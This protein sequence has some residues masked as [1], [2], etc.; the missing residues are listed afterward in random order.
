MKTLTLLVSICFDDDCLPEVRL[1]RVKWPDRPEYGRDSA[2][3]NFDDGGSSIVPR[4]P[5]VRALIPARRTR[6]GDEDR[7]ALP[8]ASFRMHVVPRS[9]IKIR[10]QLGRVGSSDP[11]PSSS[12][13]LSP[14]VAT[15]RFAANEALDTNTMA[16][17]WQHDAQVAPASRAAVAHS[18]AHV[19]LV[20]DHLC[21]AAGHCSCR[22][23]HDRQPCR[24]LRLRTR[25]SSSE[26]GCCRRRPLSG[27]RSHRRRRRPG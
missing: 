8:P 6:P 21:H 5:P 22:Q 26:K 24:R 17:R 23:A 12:S 15:R 3:E 13:G 20:Q 11:P 2:R 27:H 1:Q 16:T 7:R 14:A 10:R 4:S 25:P 9:A 19:T 18:L